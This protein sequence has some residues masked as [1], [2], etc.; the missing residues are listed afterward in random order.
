[1]NLWYKIS[2]KLTKLR[3][4]P[5]RFF[6]FH[7]VSDFFDPTT[8][9]KGDWIQTD[10][11][12][13][14]LFNYQKKYIFISLEEATCCLRKDFFRLNKYAVLTADDGW[15]SLHNILPWLNEQHVPITL[16]LNPAYLDGRHFRERESERYLS[17]EDVLQMHQ[18][19]P[20]LSIGIHGWE[21][22]DATRQTV[23]EF[24]E[25]IARS[26]DELSTLPNFIPY[27]AYAWGRHNIQT[28]NILKTKK[29]TPV[30]ID[31]L[32]NYN[33]PNHIHRELFNENVNVV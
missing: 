22:A 1:M 3:L 18:K 27:F 24:E 25:S 30:Y 4:Q 29:M 2:R 23:Q 15:A 32:K 14:T 7:Q 5:I 10:V 33:D 13:Q 6:C 19:Y 17:K 8:M 20:L 11:F 26:M 9:L 28:D 12:K 16:F 21:H 31:G